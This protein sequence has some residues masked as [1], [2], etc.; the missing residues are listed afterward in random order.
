MVLNKNVMEAVK[1][2]YF[3]WNYLCPTS[4]YGKRPT[5]GHWLWEPIFREMALKQ[6]NIDPEILRE[7][8]DDWELK[9]PFIRSLIK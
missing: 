4:I 5:R 2:L 9:E 1:A 3:R 7:F 6:G 8:A